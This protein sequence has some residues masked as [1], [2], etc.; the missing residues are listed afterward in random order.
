MWRNPIQINCTLAPPRLLASTTTFSLG[1]QE[2]D[3]A[4]HAAFQEALNAAQKASN[5]LHTSGRYPL[6]GR[7]DVNTYQV[8]ADLVAQGQLA[9]LL[10]FE[11]RGGFFPAVD[12]RAKFSVLALRARAARTNEPARLTFF[13]TDVAH[14][15]DPERVLSLTPEDFAWVPVLW[16][17]APEENLWGIKFV[18][19]FMMNTA[20]WL[21]RTRETLELE[22]FQLL[23]HRFATYDKTDTRDMTPA[24]HANPEALPLPRYWVR[25]ELDAYYARLYGL[26]RE[27]LCYILEPRSVKGPHFPGE[28]FR[29]L[30]EKEIK[31]YGEYRTMRLVLEAWDRLEHRP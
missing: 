14:L 10:D 2:S 27:E 4:L 25:A 11:N 26:T 6:A 1:L 18:L 3:P 20:S 15:S 24:E 30:K 23:G 31:A 28:T 8:F 12:S 19:M 16:R 29:V 13:A 5:F 22:G 21:F 17:E 7:D 9:A